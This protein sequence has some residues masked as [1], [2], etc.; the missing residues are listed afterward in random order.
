[1]KHRDKNKKNGRKGRRLKGIAALCVFAAIVLLWAGMF[2]SS[3]TVRLR[4]AEV[5]L[6]DL[7][8]SFDGTT[9]LF[10]SDVELCGFNNLRALK[11][12]CDSLAQLQP[13]VVLL[14]GNYVSPSLL[15]RMTDKEASGSADTRRRA[16]ERLASIPSTY[17]TYAVAG[18]DD[19]SPELLWR[20]AENT[21]IQVLNNTG[22]ILNNGTEAIYLAGLSP[23]G[24]LESISSIV[25]STMCV[26]GFA[27]DPAR[28]IDVN[29]AESKDGGRWV[30]LFLSGHNLG[31]QICVKGR[32]LLDLTETQRRFFKGWTMDKMPI[33]VS[34]G[35]GCRSFNLRLGSQAEV[36]L[37]TLR[38]A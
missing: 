22:A 36:W 2:L 8:A 12:L 9:I 20:E 7:P 6:H 11:G 19:D 14:G 15:E 18:D 13:D 29:I 1:M 27:N 3:L 31:G 33:L 5:K 26:V 25:N 37:I 38:R 35:V 23:T 28:A 34:Q 32:T 17:G 21:G 16:L 10:I 24:A 4:R 30:D